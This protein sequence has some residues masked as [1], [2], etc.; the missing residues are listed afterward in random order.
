MP[1]PIGNLTGALLVAVFL[2]GAGSAADAACATGDIQIKSWTWQRDRGWTIVAGELV[3]TCA[4]PTGVQLQL[5]FRD[6]AGRIV[7]VDDAWLFDRRDMP[8]GASQAFQVQLRA[9][10]TTRSAAIRISDLRRWGPRP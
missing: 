2:F 6:E 1:R 7:T 10:A 4:E 5:T 8:A 9:N 3:N